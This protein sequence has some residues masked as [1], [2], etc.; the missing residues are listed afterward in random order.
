MTF[1][2][3]IACLFGRLDWSLVVSVVAI[4]IA[5]VEVRRNN[6][7]SGRI[8]KARC[9]FIQSISENNEKLFAH[10]ELVIR[11]TG[12]KL[13]DPIVKLEFVGTDGCGSTAI[14]LAERKGIRG[15]AGEFERSMFAAFELKSYQFD[16]VIVTW[17]KS[18]SD[19]GKQQAAFRVYSQ[20]YLAYEFRIGGW[21][22]RAKHRWNILAQKVHSRFERTIKANDG[23]DRLHLPAWLP[24]F[25]TL[26]WQLMQFVDHLKKYGPSTDLRKPAVDAQ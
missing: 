23:T 11:N 14:E 8:K 15:A 17:F 3:H 9:S 5:I 10:F 20:S 16:P 7:A 26:E 24:T 19:P 4:Y 22:D 6:V 25:V 12:I 1:M 13:I 2:A 21:M 18:I